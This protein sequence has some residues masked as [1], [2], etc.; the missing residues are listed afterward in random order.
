[1]SKQCCNIPLEWSQKIL[2]FLYKPRPLI[3]KNEYTRF[4]G[5][6]RALSV[7]RIFRVL[8]HKMRDRFEKKSRPLCLWQ[9]QKPYEVCW[10]RFWNVWK[11]WRVFLNLE[12]WGLFTHLTSLR[13]LKVLWIWEFKRFGGLTSLADRFVRWI[14]GFDF[15][16]TSWLWQFHIQYS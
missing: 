11:I 8:T 4:K 14:N 2:F 12:I 3:S 6:M 1:M 15:K 9:G 10:R 5:T 7:W 16:R 13:S